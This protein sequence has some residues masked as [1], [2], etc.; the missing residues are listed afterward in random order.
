MWA[1]EVV[2][3]ILVGVPGAG[4]LDI[5]PLADER[6]GALALAAFALVVASV[7]AVS[8]SLGDSGT[9]AFGASACDEVGE[10]AYWYSQCVSDLFGG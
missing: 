3:A 7:L 1:V 6:E 2:A 8:V 10:S 5:E 9:G 4:A